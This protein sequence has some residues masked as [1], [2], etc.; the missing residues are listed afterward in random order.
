[1]GLN[2][3]YHTVVKRSMVSCDE[4]S[5]WSHDSWVPIRKSTL[6]SLLPTSLTA[7]YLLTSTSGWSWTWVASPHSGPSTDSRLRVHTRFRILVFF[8]SGRLFTVAYIYHSLAS[9]KSLSVTSLVGCWGSLSN[10]SVVL[11]AKS[12]NTAISDNSQGTAGEQVQTSEVLDCTLPWHCLFCFPS[13]RRL[14]DEI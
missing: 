8:N 11:S 5:V 9:L 13:S 4:V 7:S 2:H 3:I 6:D 12:R 10:I 14:Y 1:M